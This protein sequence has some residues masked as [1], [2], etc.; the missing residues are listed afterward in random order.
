[1]DR[2]DVNDLGDHTRAKTKTPAEGR[3]SWAGAKRH[4]T[5]PDYLPGRAMETS[6]AATGPLWRADT[7]TGR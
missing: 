2:L 3:W 4:H 7:P 6:A 1:M 5:A